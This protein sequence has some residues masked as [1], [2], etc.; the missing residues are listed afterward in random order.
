[1]HILESRRPPRICGC[2]HNQI[3]ETIRTAAVLSCIAKCIV[4]IDSTLLAEQ[5]AQG[6][7]FSSAL[8]FAPSSLFDFLGEINVLR[9]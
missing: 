5:V 9:N 1:M 3:T 7:T 2:S 6:P 8:F 4:S